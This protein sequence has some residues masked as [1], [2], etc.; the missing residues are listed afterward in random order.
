MKSIIL[1]FAIKINLSISSTVLTET[2]AI[3]SIKTASIENVIT[4]V[5]EK[6]K[7]II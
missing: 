1:T 6:I 3:K 4:E 5:L 7:N 2:L